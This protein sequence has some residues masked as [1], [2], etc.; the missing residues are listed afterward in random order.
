[1]KSEIR[2]FITTLD[3]QSIDAQRRVLLQPL[4]DFI[5]ARKDAAESIR[6]NFIC[7]HNSRRSHMCQV[8]AKTIAEFYNIEKVKSYSGGTEST[9]VYPTVIDTFEKLGFE[10]TKIANYTNPTYKLNF[11]EEHCPMTLFS[12]RHNDRYNPKKDFAAVMTCT[13]ADQNCP[14]IP[15]ATRISL[16]YVD[17]KIS[18]GTNDEVSVYSER[19]TQIATEIKYV[20]SKIK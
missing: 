8:W 14:I 4:I 16:P 5:Q 10:I 15:N 19:S 9:A 17:P 12:K 2:H 3:E 11:T 7:T 18:D 20:F 1:M 13:D 6:L